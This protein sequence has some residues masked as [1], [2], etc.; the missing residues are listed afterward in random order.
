MTLTNILTIYMALMLP[1]VISVNKELRKAGLDQM[2]I[3]KGIFLM[4]N[5][6][7]TLPI[8]YFLFFKEL[9]LKKKK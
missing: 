7:I 4:I 8:W 3:P 6:F 2:S 5:M 1:M 9:F